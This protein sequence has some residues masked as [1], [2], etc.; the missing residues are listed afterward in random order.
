MTARV[1]RPSGRATPAQTH[2]A[3][4]GLAEI[5]FTWD[6]EKYLLPHP[7]QW[8]LDVFEHVEMNEMVLACKALLGPVQWARYRSK[9]RTFPNLLD[10]FN[11]MWAA[12]GVNSGE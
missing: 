11:A 12:A 7:D 3:E 5:E 8:D 6:G 4:T 10:M 9:R 2:R 1:R